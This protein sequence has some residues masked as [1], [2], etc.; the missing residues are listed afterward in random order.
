MYCTYPDATLLWFTGIED[1][2]KWI[3][4]DNG[5]PG[6]ASIIAGRILQWW[7]HIGATAFPDVSD[8]IQA[9][10]SRQDDIGWDIFCFSTMVFQWRLVQEEYL[11]ESDKFTTSVS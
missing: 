9:V 8:E 11:R 1:I 5:V 4:T 2:R 7:V 3:N 6:L 10:L